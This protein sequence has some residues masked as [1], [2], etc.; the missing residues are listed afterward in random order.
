[1]CAVSVQLTVDWS[2]E[3]LLG[4]GGF[5]D[6]RAATTRGGRCV[7]KLVRVEDEML[8]GDA[9]EAMLQEAHALQQVHYPGV[10]RL[11]GVVTD[12][13]LTD[14]RGRLVSPCIIM[15]HVRNSVPLSGV[16]RPASVANPVLAALTMPLRAMLQSS[17]A[18]RVH[19][20]AQIARAVAAVHDTG[21]T[22]GDLKCSNVLV[23]YEHG[24]WQVRL[25]DFGLS[26]CEGVGR[27]GTPAYM[28][29]ELLRSHTDD[30][31]G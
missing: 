3:G 27:G 16:L 11:L 1:M 9:T 2:V 7:V 17:V 29:P 14:S 6:V 13:T 15:E 8:R 5:G 26:R 18:A 12:P 30:P 23:L 19:V 31:R 21:L 22:H 4:S 24:E 10:I 20:L 25:L 28:A